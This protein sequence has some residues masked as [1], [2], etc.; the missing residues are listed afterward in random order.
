MGA[1]I[2]YTMVVARACVLVCL[3]YFFSS[4]PVH[5]E[6]IE[7]NSEIVGLF[8][9]VDEKYPY[10]C[11]QSPDRSRG[12]L[13]GLLKPKKIDLGNKFKV[14]TSKKA[15]KHFRKLKKKKKKFALSYREMKNSSA[16]ED[17]LK[18]LKKKVK[19]FRLKIKAFKTS[20]SHCETFVPGDG[21]NP[22]PPPASLTPTS[23]TLTINENESVNFT[24]KATNANG[25]LSF[26]IVSGPERGTITGA[27]PDLTYTSA[28][29]FIGEEVLIFS[30][31]DDVDTK[32]GTIIFRVDG[33]E[34]GFTGDAYSLEPYRETLTA[35][36]MR[37]IMNKLFG[38]D[39]AILEAGIAG[40]REAFVEALIAHESYAPESFNRRASSGNYHT[41]DGT[42][43]VNRQFIRNNPLRA[44]IVYQLM[45]WFSVNHEAFNNQEHYDQFIPAYIDLY[46]NSALNFSGRDGDEGQGGLGDSGI[47]SE[48]PTPGSFHQLVLDQLSD[49]AMLQYLD[50]QYNTRQNLNE[51]YGR[52]VMELFTLGNYEV[53]SGEQ[54]FTEI[55]MIESTRA[56][57][58]HTLKW[59]PEGEDGAP[60]FIPFV[61]EWYW[62]DGPKQMFAGKAWETEWQTSS[63]QA[64]YQKLVH[65]ILYR[66]PGSGRYIAGTL[67]SRLIHPYMTDEFLDALSAEFKS[68][69]YHIGE[70]VKT[71]LNSSA[72]YSKKARRPCIASPTEA[73]VKMVKLAKMD[74]PDFLL[75][76]TALDSLWVSQALFNDDPLKPPSVFGT[77]GCGVF[78]DTDIMRGE[79][80]LAPHLLLERI[81]GFSKLLYE[82]VRNWDRYPPED[83]NPPADDGDATDY[84]ARV[85]LPEVEPESTLD[86]IIYFE[87][88]FDVQLT[89]AEREIVLN[90]TGDLIDKSGNGYVNDLVLEVKL[91]GLLMIFF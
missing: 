62:D 10:S 35:Q 64:D 41:Q 57:T 45:D 75:D 39:Q 36:E 82:S 24:L 28:F 29:H 63:P 31:S 25:P 42:R 84:S 40:G 13:F 15:K 48:A 87:D 76:G 54:Q 81:N 78:R 51:N 58:G 37:H 83:E 89:D 67:F 20:T 1:E 12:N 53:I 7:I 38:G 86:L 23:L 33:D 14:L 79:V 49:G 70:F 66:H 91:R 9:Q 4:I 2:L 46:V 19:K 90:Y 30:V 6:I 59:I 50:N 73:I 61:E 77:E 72:A 11:F 43:H 74:T 55:D 80:H 22:F 85:I 32:E 69:G 65:T 52:E 8:G 88:Y 44:M 17:E 26:S 21:T 34:E 5:A 56:C 60:E 68:S 3:V 27:V 18:K 16:S 71:I 47:A